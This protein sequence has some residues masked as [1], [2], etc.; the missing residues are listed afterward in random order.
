M[1]RALPVHTT[2]QGW[3]FYSVV[4]LTTMYIPGLATMGESAAALLK[5]G[6]LLPQRKKNVYPRMT[7]MRAAFLYAPSPSA[8]QSR[9]LLWFVR[10]LACRHLLAAVP[11]GAS[12]KGHAQDRPAGTPASFLSQAGS[13]FREF[14]PSGG[15]GDSVSSQ[16]SVDGITF[17]VRSPLQKHFGSFVAACITWIIID[18]TWQH[19]FRSLRSNR[20]QS[21]SW[22]ALER[23]YPPH[24]LSAPHRLKALRSIPMAAFTRPLTLTMTGFWASRCWTANTSWMGLAP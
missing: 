1:C 6:I 17:F 3:T 2:A 9:H 10:K 13:A 19:I 23:R 8:R 5:D 4:S 7:S 24:W 14:T 11:M 18:V 16:G 21:S 20:Q 12:R 15:G 22:T